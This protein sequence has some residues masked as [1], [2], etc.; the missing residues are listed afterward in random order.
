MHHC[1]QN[2]LQQGILPSLLLK[3]NSAVFAEIES[4]ETVR[5]IYTGEKSPSD[6]IN[7]EIP[8]DSEFY[9]PQGGESQEITY[10]YTQAPAVDAKALTMQ[11]LTGLS[12]VT[13]GH[14][15]MYLQYPQLFPQTNEYMKNFA[16]LPSLPSVAQSTPLGIPMVDII[17]NLADE[18]MQGGSEFGYNPHHNPN[19]WIEKVLSGTIVG[20]SMSPFTNPLS[21]DLDGDGIETISL[22]DSNVY[23]DNDNDGFAQKI[24]WASGQYGILVLDRNN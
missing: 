22:T 8:E 19:F 18:I 4:F 9:I 2:N 7:Y 14:V 5:D 15:L 3:G 13:N 17:N 16:G 10:Q 21:V 6:L 20:Q 24:S 23:F 1:S 12:I 11:M